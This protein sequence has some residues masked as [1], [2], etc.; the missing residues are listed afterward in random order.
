[1]PRHEKSLEPDEELRSI[2]FAQDAFFTSRRIA[3]DT[4]LSVEQAGKLR[5]AAAE[6]TRQI[7]AAAVGAPTPFAPWH[8]AGPNPIVQIGRTSG[9]A[10]AVSGRIGA[11]AIQ[12]GTG[13]FIL[14]AAQGGI[15]TYDTAAGVWVPRTDDQPSLAIGALAVAPSAPNTVYAGTGEGALSGD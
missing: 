9:G 6:R 8:P 10:E 12:P 1:V 11:L 5:A 3:G 15:W 13:R 14:G 4:P 7:R 2:A